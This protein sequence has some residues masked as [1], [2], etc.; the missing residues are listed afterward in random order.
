MCIRDRLITK[1]SSVSV[2]IDDEEPEKWLFYWASDP[3][4]SYTLIND[5][6]TAYNNEDNHGLIK[7]NKHQKVPK[8][9]EK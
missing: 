1:S 8:S 7:F 5:P 2:K 6:K 4:E 3:Q 9:R